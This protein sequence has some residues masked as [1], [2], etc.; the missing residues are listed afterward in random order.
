[1]ERKWVLG[2]D[3]SVYDNLMDGFTFHDIIQALRQERV[4]DSTTARLVVKNILTTNLEDM[5][6]LLEK[7]LVAI[8]AAAKR[9]RSDYED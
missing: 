4:I 5:N 1:M 7:N 2:D 9:G 3:V 6:F 8:I